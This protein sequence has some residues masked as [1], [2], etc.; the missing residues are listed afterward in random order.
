MAN[1]SPVVCCALQAWFVYL[2]RCFR[3]LQISGDYTCKFTFPASF[4]KP[5]VLSA[6]G[7]N[8]YTFTIGWNRVPAVAFCLTC[9]GTHQTAFSAVPSPVH[10]SIYCPC[11]PTDPAS[12][13]ALRG[14]LVLSPDTFKSRNLNVPPA[15]INTGS[16]CQNGGVRTDVRRVQISTRKRDSL[17]WTWLN[18]KKWGCQRWSP[19]A[20]HLDSYHVAL[21]IFQV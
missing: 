1:L 13:Q 19:T 6:V 11:P 18:A 9:A 21:K 15:G 7:W 8:S 14:Q 20:C 4:E 10:I 16:S 5:E 17:F 12:L 3:K 2:A